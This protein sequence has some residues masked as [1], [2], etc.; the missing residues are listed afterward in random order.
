MS[1]E[2]QIVIENADEP[3]VPETTATSETIG[4]ENSSTDDGVAIKTD[5]QA[6]EK[7]HAT[8][9]RKND[10]A[11]VT[12]VL[13]SCVVGTI[14]MRIISYFMPAYSTY[15]GYLL[16]QAAFSLPVQLLLFLAA[17]FCIYKFVGKRTVRQTLEF[18]SYTKFSPCFLLAFPL[19]IAVYFIT[20][21]VSS[22]WTG[23]LRMTGYTV[24]SGAPDMP[25]EFNAGF[26]VAEILMTA[27]L[28]AV[29][30]EFA[31][32][33]G[34]LTTAKRSFSR[35]ACVLFCAVAFGLFHQNIRQ[36]F[37]TALFGALAAYLVYETE[38]IYPAVF[39]HFANNFCSVYFD[40]A[41]NYG[42]FGGGLFDVI[43]AAPGWAL[44]LAF[45]AIILLCVALVIFML[46]LHEKRA[47]EKKRAVLRGGGMLPV[48]GITQVK[49]TLYELAGVIALGTV[50]ALTT[51]F[52]YAWG[53][54]Y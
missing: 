2:K 46:Y 6:V 35:L 43:T 54:L 42:F 21:G 12:L 5:I 3:V 22:G 36:V 45:F 30:E 44:A 33:G 13:L 8:P 41:S 24:P 50:A 4:G 11:C 38:S 25:T 52:T 53:F 14:V 17:P 37:Y 49:P 40:Y 48:G 18:G 23:M 31:M 27:V 16:S 15:G 34:L 20:I 32:R 10:W 19:G 1:D 51:L 29:C 9:T 47:L 39:M 28:P 7:H 26:L